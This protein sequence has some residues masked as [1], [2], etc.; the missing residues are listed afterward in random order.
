MI[1]SIPRRDRFIVSALPTGQQNNGLYIED[2]AEPQIHVAR[3]KEHVL[4]ARS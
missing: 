3:R 4:R 2:A 1:V